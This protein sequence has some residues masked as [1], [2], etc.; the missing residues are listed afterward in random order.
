MAM[1]VHSILPDFGYEQMKTSDGRNGKDLH[2]SIVVA[3]DMK[4]NRAGR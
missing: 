3:D 1:R 2:A 4:N